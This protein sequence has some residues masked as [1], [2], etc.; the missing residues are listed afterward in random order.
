MTD[1]S[2]PA[3]IS[4]INNEIKNGINASM[5]TSP[6]TNV[7]VS[8]VANLNSRILFINSLTIATS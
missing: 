2:Q 8:I 4:L 3:L 5:I 6:T 7:G 1:K